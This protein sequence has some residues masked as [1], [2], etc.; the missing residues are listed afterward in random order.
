MQADA[1]DTAGTRHAELSVAPHAALRALYRA[2]GG[3]IAASTLAPS[4]AAGP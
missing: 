3:G 1:F 4:V 2:F